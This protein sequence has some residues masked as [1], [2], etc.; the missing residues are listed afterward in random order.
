M[1]LSKETS[2]AASPAITTW[3]ETEVTTDPVWEAAYLRFETPKQETRKFKQRLKALGA[4][5]WPRD[6]RI[7]ELFCGRGSGLCALQEMGFTQVEGVDLSLDLLK[8]F[9][10]Q[11]QLYAGDCRKLLFEDNSRDIMIVQGG[12]HHLRHLPGDLDDVL[13]ECSRVL[14]PGGRI[15][16]V[17]PW[18]TPFLQLVHT[19]CTNVTLRVYWPKI[20]ALAEMIE[21]EGETYRQWL[22]HSEMILA[23]LQ[24]LFTAEICRT[25]WG[26]LF[27]VGQ[28]T[29]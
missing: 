6:S 19:A 4:R 10:G 20:D 13:Y 14:V 28:K 11:F 23:M 1:S 7:V 8:T 15:V 22:S 12:L 21:R 2:P 3:L 25:R 27:Y 24:E 9:A 29:E 16:V 5:R 18:L 26:K 17:E